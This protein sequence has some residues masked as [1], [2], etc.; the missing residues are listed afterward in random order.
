[1]LL[2]IRDYI[3]REKVVSTQQLCREFCVDYPAL[4]P[5]LNLLVLK[6]FIGQCKEQEGC[7]KSC[8]KCRSQV[9]EYYQA[10]TS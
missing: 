7:K 9:I 2:Q 3:V 1:M 8:F 6:G 10:V 4:Q 5:I